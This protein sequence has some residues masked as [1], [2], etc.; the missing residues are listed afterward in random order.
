MKA[1]KILFSIVAVLAAL[2]FVA[3]IALFSYDNFYYTLDQLPQGEHLV[4]VTSRDGRFTVNM[5]KIE[6]SMGVALR[7][8]LFDYKTKTLKNVYW[9]NGTDSATVFWLNEKMVSINQNVVD[10]TVDTFDSRRPIIDDTADA[11]AALSGKGRK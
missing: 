11:L 10:I 7:G 5:Y 2:T 8:E 6:N 1:K 4:S 9:E 3:N